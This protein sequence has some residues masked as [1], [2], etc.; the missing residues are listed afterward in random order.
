MDIWTASNI[1]AIVNK[2]V[3][4]IQVHG[5][6]GW[7]QVGGAWLWERWMVYSPGREKCINNAWNQAGSR[8]DLGQRQ[9]STLGLVW[10]MLLYY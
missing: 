9:T 7:Q 10:A 6:G 3:M 5:E 2:A 1:F 4:N 8:W